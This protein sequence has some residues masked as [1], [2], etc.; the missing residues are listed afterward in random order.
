MTP[1][2]ELIIIDYKVTAK[3]GE[4]ILDQDYHESYRRQ[5]DLYAWLFVMNNYP[6]Y[7]RAYLFYLNGIKDRPTLENS[8]HFTST[9]IEHTLNLSWI[10]E[11]LHKIN[12]CLNH[13]EPPPKSQKCSFCQFVLSVNNVCI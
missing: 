9:L 7:T 6:V 8:L 13:F 2:G 4:I 1:E 12:E 10:E 5:L 11:V 3:S